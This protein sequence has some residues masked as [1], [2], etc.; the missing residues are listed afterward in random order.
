[1]TDITRLANIEAV[2]RELRHAVL[3][4]NLSTEDAEDLLAAETRRRDGTQR[5]H[6]HR[7]EAL[8]RAGVAEDEIARLTR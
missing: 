4:D 8:R 3:F 5:A 6:E 1:V 7:V 2:E